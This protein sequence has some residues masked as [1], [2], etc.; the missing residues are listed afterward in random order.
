MHTSSLPISSINRVFFFFILLG[1]TYLTFKVAAPYFGIISLGLIVVIL[2]SPIYN[3]IH[4]LVGHNTTIATSLSVLLV[5]L[6]LL[7][8]LSFF[9][10]VTINQARTFYETVTAEGNTTIQQVTYQINTLLERFPNIQFR[11]TEESIRTV[12]NDNIKPDKLG[13]L[14][15][16]VLNNAGNVGAFLINSIIN[17]IVFLL[18]LFTL[19]PNH[20][21]LLHYFRRISPLADEIDQLYIQRVIAMSKAMLLGTLIIAITQG[22]LSGIALWTVGVPYVFFW[23][24]IITFFSLLPIGATW[25]NIPIAVVLILTGQVWQGWAI[26]AYH[27]VLVNNI[28]NVLR[29]KLVPKEASLPTVLMFVSILGGIAYFKYWGFIY[30]PVVMILFITSLEV[31]LKYYHEKKSS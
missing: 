21:R 31:Y 6:C 14:G 1:L 27:F 2:F 23:T 7:I 5:I 24:T 16:Y 25:V 19:F 13:E 3:R 4:R 8:P 15:G 28:D 12:L 20:K 30:G 11:L 18:V 17:I 26:I 22:V 9:A 10:V 29:V